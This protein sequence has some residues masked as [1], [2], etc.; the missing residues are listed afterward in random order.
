MINWK[1]NLLFVW[2]AQF[3]STAGFSF[4][5]PFIPFY[6]R[7][8]G[9]SDPREASMWVALF[10]A[11]GNLSLCLFSPFWG[12][13]SDIYGRR[14]MMLRANFASALLLPLM[15]FVPGAGWLVLVRFLVGFFSGTLTAAQILVSSC[16]PLANRGFALGSLSSAVCGG[17]MAG[18]FI[19]GVIVD[20]F[21]YRNAFFLSGATLLTSG[22]LILFGVRE[23][24]KI[25]TSFRSAVGKIQFR[26][27]DFGY[28]WL[29]LLLVFVTG[30][31]RRFDTPF[32]PLLVETVNGPQRAATWT[33]VLSGLSAAAGIVSGSLLG[34]LADRF[35][36]PKVA[37]W[38][39]LLAGLLM[40]PQGLAQGL[41][42]LIITRLGMIFFAGGLDPVFQIWLSKATPDNKRGMFFGWATSIKSFGWFISS[43][44]SGGVAM[45]LG[46]RW[47]FL[48]TGLIFLLLIP[49]IKSTTRK[50]ASIS[51]PVA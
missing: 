3:L 28:V 10:A 51:A 16:T 22:F 47:V 25:T 1:R 45:F 24:F 29:I 48:V 15:A 2:L 49:I 4:S 17:I 36:V 18:T 50:I 6:I 12:F 41:T 40:I 19:G 42:M 32:L 38:S 11:S 5:M 39:A 35:S 43:M 30:F 7:E 46:V 21:G 37:V 34:W 8:L 33:G 14:I 9:V 23:N 27:P 44:T 20:Y 13:V 26:I 31:A